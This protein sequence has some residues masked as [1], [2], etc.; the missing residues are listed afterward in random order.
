MH[1]DKIHS[2][3]SRDVVTLGPKESLRAAVEK[4]NFYKV[5]C[6]VVVEDKRPAGILTERDIVRLISNNIDINITTLMSAMN[7][8]VIAVSEEAEL[9]EV[10]NLMVINDLRRLVV[11]DEG[12]NVIG[13]ITQTDIIKNLNVDSFVSFRKMEQIM[14]RKIVSMRKE[15][16]LLRA[17]E[18]MAQNRI[19]CVPVVED[20]RPA[21]I[22]TERDIT[23]VIAENSALNNNIEAI[24]TSPV[25]TVS[26]DV[27]LYD[28]TRLMEENKFRRLVVV[29]PE[30]Y[31]IGIATQSDIIRNIRE[32]YMELL[33]NMLKEKSRELVESEIKYRTLVERSLEGI[34]IIQEG[35]S[36]LSILLSSKF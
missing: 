36:N 15:D 13:I 21:G 34:I 26:K 16:S 7:S 19:S 32:D 29:D 18:L 5:G 35:L 14:K 2:I 23:R 25:L 10:A 31:M 3:I 8:P 4:M 28:A 33:K 11:V 1:L 6:V 22:I 17:V 12:R 30:G 20:N 9:P 27:N 24:M